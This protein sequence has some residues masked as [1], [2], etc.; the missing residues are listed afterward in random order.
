MAIKNRK[1]FSSTMRNDLEERLKALSA[2][3]DIPVSKLLDQAINLLL[4]QYE[5]SIPRDKNRTLGE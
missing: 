5:D 2:E 4:K 3:T 1:R